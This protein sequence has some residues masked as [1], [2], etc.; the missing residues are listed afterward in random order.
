MNIKIDDN[1]IQKTTKC[2]RNF[3][4]LSGETTLCKVEEIMGD[5][6]FIKC[7]DSNS[8]EYRFY[9]GYS[10]ICNCPV[11]KELYKRNKI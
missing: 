1:I 4:C 5:V 6:I 11:R 9:F 10:Q 7:M 3:S 8:C 2:R